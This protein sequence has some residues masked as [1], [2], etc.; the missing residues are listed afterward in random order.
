M[1]RPTPTGIYVGPG[2]PGG[3]LTMNKHDVLPLL[4]MGLGLVACGE[5]NDGPLQLDAP[6]WSEEKDDSNRDSMYA[7][8]MQVID[9][10]AKEA[11]A[12]PKPGLETIF[13]DVYEDVPQHIRKQGEATFD[14]AKRKGLADAGDGEFPL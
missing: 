11:E 2:M 9:K 12:T 6:A 10:A 1:N 8:A 5:S 7:E 13:S 3:E 14:L 4:M